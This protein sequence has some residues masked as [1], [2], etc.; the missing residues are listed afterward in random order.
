M[1]SRSKDTKRRV[2]V[3]VTVVVTG[4]LALGLAACSRGGSS[5]SGLDGNTLKMYT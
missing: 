5:T 4:A 3:G 2:R 1:E